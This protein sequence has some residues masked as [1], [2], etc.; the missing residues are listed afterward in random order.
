MR[1]AVFT[2]ITSSELQAI[3]NLVL[4]DTICAIIAEIRMSSEEAL[5]NCILYSHLLFDST[6]VQDASREYVSN[7]L[8]FQRTHKV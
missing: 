8:P 5:C 6:S 2:S 7:E 3:C 4:D 1:D